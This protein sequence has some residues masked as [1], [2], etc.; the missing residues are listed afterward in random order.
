M[1]KFQ[2]IK[3]T[4]DLLPTDE[5]EPWKQ[6]SLW[7]VVRM[8]AQGVAQTYGFKEIETPIFENTDLF[9]KSTGETTDIVQKEMYSFED[10]GGR[11][12]TL[13]PEGTPPCLRALIE[14]GTLNRPGFHNYYYIGPMFRYE[15][16]QQ[17]RYR[18]FYQFGIEAIG[19]HSPEQDAD[20]IALGW[21]LY[22]KLG[23]TKKTLLLNTLGDHESRKA[24]REQLIAYFTPLK[25]KLS[26]DSQNRL[27]TNP[28][29]I[30]DSKD[31]GDKALV[32]DAP[33]LSSCLNEESKQHFERVKTCL[34]Q[35]DIPYSEDPNLVRGL[36]YYSHTVFEIT[37]E[38]IGAQSSA[39]SGGRYNELVADLGGPD[40]PAV[41]FAMGFE[42]TIQ[43]MLAQ[44]E[45]L[46]GTTAPVSVLFAAMG[47]K[48]NDFS[49]EFCQRLRDAHIPASLDFSGRKLKTILE[50]A[51]LA[52]IPYVVVVGDE[53]IQKGKVQLKLMK[54]H[55]EEEVSFR[56]LVPTLKV[57][58]HKTLLDESDAQGLLDCIM[59]QIT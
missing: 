41:G 14:S 2:R 28:L 24:Y 50:R 9:R 48:A 40:L 11:S 39:L 54:E 22:D 29:R 55:K 46:T 10:K 57:K 26:E 23:I 37:C 1:A 52:N 45:G 30:L 51:N 32:K 56:D 12:I 6:S 33:K 27:E 17:G 44:N 53:E 59:D 58:I 47:E 5:K 16:P 25:D 8:S 4:F 43:A 31:D 19:N 36:D 7:Q 13:R 34:K 42:R 21:K 35:M 15:R 20:I 3:G 18:Q 38:G 49:M